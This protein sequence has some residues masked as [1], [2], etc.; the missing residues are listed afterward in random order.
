MCSGVTT[1]GAGPRAPCSPSCPQPGP[2]VLSASPSPQGEDTGPSLPPSDGATAWGRKGPD[3]GVR[4]FS[5]EAVISG[6]VPGLLAGVTHL[7]WHFYRAC[8]QAGTE[9]LHGSGDREKRKAP[10]PLMSRPI[11]VHVIL[12]SLPSSGPM[13]WP[14]PHPSGQAGH[15]WGVEASL[16][17]GPL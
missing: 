15:R 10:G 12:L 7:H 14:H 2:G 11:P 8:L 1:A 4:A 16:R 3:D 13:P 9:Q 17:S 5:G 6:W